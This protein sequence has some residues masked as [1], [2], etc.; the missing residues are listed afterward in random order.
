MK[1]LSI[2]ILY[3]LS[4]ILFLTVC[5][6]WIAVPEEQVLNGAVSIIFLILLLIAVIL[7]LGRWQKIYRSK[8]FMKFSAQLLS[9][10]LVFAILG[11]VNYL[12]YKRP[13]QWD[14]SKNARNSLSAQSIKISQQLEGELEIIVFARKNDFPAIMKLLE[15]YRFHKNDIVFK[16]VD[17][18]LNPAEVSA[19]GITTAPTL[20]FNYN[21]KR[22]YISELNELNI[23]NALIKVSRER[24]PLVC[25]STGHGEGD[26]DDKEPEGLSY[27][28]TKIL[29]SNLVLRTWSLLE[30]GAI[31]SECNL[32]LIWGPTTDFTATDLKAL[33]VYLKGG[34]HL[35]VGLDPDVNKDAVPALRAFLKDWGVDIINALAVDLLSHAHGSNGVAPIVKTFEEAHPI[36]KGFNLPVFFPLVGAVTSTEAQSENFTPLASSNISPA[37]WL[38]MTPADIAQGKLT[39]DEKVDVRG[40]LIYAGAWKQKASE[41]NA[42]IVAFANTGFVRNSYQRFNGNFNFFLNS[43]LWGVDEGRLIS[44]DLPSL[45]D[46]P[47]FIS[48]PQKGVIFYFSVLFVP[49][50][51]LSLAL[52]VYWRRK[53]Q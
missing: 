26:L 20:I 29:S 24:D 32:F 16:T 10:I 51:F 6:L 50:A 25:Y 23:T 15:L 27:L 12:A 28:Q 22:E 46:D 34:G 9:A 5:G 41:G 47:I 43:L 7:D 45:P 38:D 8:Q 37:A 14:L 36:S 39:F 2:L 4:F 30:K 11:L 13:L 42:L 49:F 52:V 31:D 48:G 17:V 1:K 40:P 53:R 3:I 18:E 21:N 44:F 33:E 19:N 35:M